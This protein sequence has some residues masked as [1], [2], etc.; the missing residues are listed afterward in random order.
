MSGV[1]KIE[2]I[3]EITKNGKHFFIKY[4]KKDER[5]LIREISKY[6]RNFIIIETNYINL[7]DNEDSIC[8]N[9]DKINLDLLF[10]YP[11]IINSSYAQQNK[12]TFKN[13]EKYN[14]IYFYLIP[15]MDYSNTKNHITKFE[16]IMIENMTKYCVFDS[17]IIVDNMLF[18]KF[19]NPIFINKDKVKRNKFLF[20]MGGI[21]D[22]FITF[23]IVNEYLQSSKYEKIY[24][25][26]YSMIKS[27]NFEHIVDLFY[28]SDPRVRLLNHHHYRHFITHW[29]RYSENTLMY[30]QITNMFFL[31]KNRTDHAAFLYKKILIGE[32]DLNFYKSTDIFKDKILKSVTSEEKKYI[33][34]LVKNKKNNIGLQYFTGCFEEEHNKWS[35]FGDRKWDEQNVKNFIKKCTENDM[36]LIILNS[37]TYASPLQEF[38]T[39]P[40]SIAG[41]ALL[42]SKMDLVIGVDSSA[43][44]IASFYNIPSIT[45]WGKGSPLVLNYHKDKPTYIGY[46]VLRKNYSIIT[47]N[48]ELSSIDFNM[49]FSLVKNFTEN[50]LLFNDKIITYQDSINKYNLL[51]F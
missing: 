1:P 17:E 48:Q 21:G 45:L 14:Y 6:Y 24:I 4:H 43:G 16:K 25:V 5:F 50:K 44:H 9:Y 20:V 51:H 38:C 10:S 37:E 41:Y 26:N 13:F 49:V 15:N 34:Q 42:I 22:F 8:L 12:V 36:N 33:D 19:A 2:T 46:R 23:S 11:I 30:R 7:F 47:K 31:P 18:L 29:L 3:T 28:G 40:L 39:R 32:K 27:I 35:F